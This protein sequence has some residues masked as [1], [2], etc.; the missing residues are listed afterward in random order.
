MCFFFFCVT[1]RVMTGPENMTCT[2]LSTNQTQEKTDHEF[3]SK[4]SFAL[5]VVYRPFG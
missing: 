3:A 4:N 1:I 2:A 5:E